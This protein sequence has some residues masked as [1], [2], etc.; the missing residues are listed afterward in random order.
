MIHVINNS[1]EFR[2]QIHQC[3]DKIFILQL[4]KIKQYEKTEFQ[5]LK[6]II[7]LFI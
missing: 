5:L 7:L 4:Q 3:A 6:I 2:I 1:Q